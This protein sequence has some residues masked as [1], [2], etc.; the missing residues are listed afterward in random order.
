MALK[1]APKNNHLKVR[2]GKKPGKKPGEKPGKAPGR[3]RQPATRTPAATLAR[4]HHGDLHSALLAAAERVLER[5]GLQGLTLRAA[6]REAGVSHAAPAHH[7]GDLTGLLSE[8]AA[9]GFRKFNDTIAKARAADPLPQAAFDS[10][11]EAYVR[12]ALAHP[13]LFQLMFRGERLDMQRPAL[14]EALTAS[15][16]N[17]AGAVGAMRH[18]SVNT[19]AL[20]LPQAADMVR[21]W[22][23]VHGFALLAQH[24]RLNPILGR[25][26]PGTDVIALLRAVLVSKTPFPH[27]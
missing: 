24:G 6:A 19:T 20:S 22:S 1:K 26:P 2:P 7:F 8:L 3:G 11:G 9:V 27:V 21:A 16:R 4:Y 10:T 5:D 18:E 15:F 23:M 25:L 12:F 14:Q 17:F 13:G